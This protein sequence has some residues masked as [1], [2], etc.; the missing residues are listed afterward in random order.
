MKSHVTRV[1]A[2]TLISVDEGVDLLAHL[3]S[4]ADASA[5]QKFHTT[6]GSHT[7]QETAYSD[8]QKKLIQQD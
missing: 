5:I 1:T 7:D 2:A 3:V 6:P 8:T 4:L